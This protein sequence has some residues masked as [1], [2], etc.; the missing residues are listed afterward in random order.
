MPLA[1]SECYFTKPHTK[2]YKKIL[3]QTNKKT[4]P[5]EQKVVAIYPFPEQQGNSIK[6]HVLN[7]LY[8]RSLW[9]KG[10][11]VSMNWQ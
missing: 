2:T 7:Q 1:N 5:S 6:E 8:H 4:Q 3:K 10:L 9:S 11:Y